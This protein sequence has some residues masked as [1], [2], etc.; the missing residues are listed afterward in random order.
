MVARGFRH[1]HTF[2]SEPKF[3]RFQSDEKHDLLPWADPYI[4]SLFADLE[5]PTHNVHNELEPPYF[6]EEDDNENPWR[7]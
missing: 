4:A 3:L 6:A 2:L 1:A 7:R 5:S